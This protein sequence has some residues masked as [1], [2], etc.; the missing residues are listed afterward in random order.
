MY[1]ITSMGPSAIRRTDSATREPCE[2]LGEPSV[3]PSSPLVTSRLADYRPGAKVAPWRPNCCFASMTLLR[4]EALATCSIILAKSRF[5]FRLTI[6]LE[7]PKRS[8]RSEVEAI[9]A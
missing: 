6:F 9:T 2:H 7:Y 5:S 8:A 4:P 1:L 3:P